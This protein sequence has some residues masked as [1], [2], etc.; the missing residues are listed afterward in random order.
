MGGTNYPLK[1][2]EAFIKKFGKV[3]FPE[4]A[5]NEQRYSGWW[6]IR[7]RTQENVN[8]W[9]NS[10]VKQGTSDLLR[11]VLRE[12]WSADVYGYDYTM[13]QIMK[14]VKRNITYTSDQLAWNQPEYWQTVSETLTLRTGDCEDGAMLI[15]ALAV[16]AGIPKSRMRLQWG[17]VIGGG[18]A[19]VV[20]YREKDAAE[21]VVDWCYW[22][23]SIVFKY[24]MWLG[25]DIRYQDVWGTARLK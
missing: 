2:S 25:Y 10:N 19:Y 16:I 3:V 22:W 24:K 23:T 9:F 12:G 7:G 4:L 17:K 15:M 20:Y 1:F 13:H 14:W 8:K 21:V 6:G 11:I 5:R 18:H